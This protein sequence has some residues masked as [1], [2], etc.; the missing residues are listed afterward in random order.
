MFERVAFTFA[1]DTLVHMEASGVAIQ[2]VAA[3]LGSSS[4]QYLDFSFYGMGSHWLNADEQVLLWLNEEG[5][6]LN[7]FTWRNPFLT[8]STYGD[9]LFT[10]VLPD[11]V[12]FNSSLN[13]IFSVAL[14]DCGP[15]QMVVEDRVWLQNNPSEQAQINCFN[16]GYAGFNRKLELVFG[17]GKLEVVWV[18][19]SKGEER[20]LRG[21]LV[22]IWGEPILVN[23]TWDV[24]A[25]GR[26]SIRKDKPELL[27][28][29]DE[30]IPIYL[31]LF[32]SR[33]N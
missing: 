7:L 8:A 20:R 31:N 24:F 14:R 13:E 28:L 33:F 9:D 3:A 22:G 4:G 6:H 10:A 2:P 29:S 21:W 5:R 26:I 12:A 15:V 32:N 1:D 23:E 19:T 25:D 17:D 27:I 18:L 11:I 16:Y 30:M